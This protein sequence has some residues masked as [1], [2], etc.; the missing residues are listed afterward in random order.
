MR[1]AS[2]LATPRACARTQARRPLVVVAVSRVARLAAFAACIGLAAFAAPSALAK[3]KKN[4]RDKIIE[5]NKK[6]LESYA[7]ENYDEALD[8][9][10][11]AL[12]MAREARMDDDKLNARTY[13]HLGAVYWTGFR[14]NEKALECFTQAKQI[15]PDIQLTSAIETPELRTMFELATVEPEKEPL[16]PK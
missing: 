4:P 14:N 10:A 9:L 1:V 12:K 15:R 11:S 5:L 13:V 6:A 8:F 3:G 2:C 7:T 16:A